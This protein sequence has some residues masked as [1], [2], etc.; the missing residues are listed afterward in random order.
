MRVSGY[1]AC[2]LHWRISILDLQGRRSSLCR[3][4]THVKWRRHAGKPFDRSA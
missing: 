2:V 3:D 1:G 4:A